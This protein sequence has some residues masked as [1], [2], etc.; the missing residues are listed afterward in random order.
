MIEFLTALGEFRFLQYATLA[1]FL[2]SIGCG[3][4][5][6]YVVVKRIGFL[7]GGIAHTVLAGMGI[8]YFMNADP[9]NGALIAALIAAVL[10]G[11]IKLQWRQDEDI[12]IA[13]FWSTGMAIGVIFISRSP[14]YNLDLMSYLFGNI[15]LVSRDALIM[16]FV[17]DCFLVAIVYI[18]YRQFLITAFDEEFARIRGVNVSATYILMLCLI[19]LSIVLMIQMV[20]LILVMA[21]LVLPAASAAQFTHSFLSMMLMAILLSIIAT[22]SGLMISYQPD[23]PSGATMV[24][25]ATAIYILTVLLNRNR[26]KG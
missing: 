20:G 13:A 4:T 3:I 19:A 16:M 23:L 22:V 14:G 12:L 10:I 6:S 26:R 21:L 11:L 17:L 8:A 18:F 9:I 15:L 5:G 7:S 25:M 2:A 24:L 1:C